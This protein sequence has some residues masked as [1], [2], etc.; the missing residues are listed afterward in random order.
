MR[1]LPLS[2]DDLQLLWDICDEAWESV[3]D[4]IDQNAHDEDL[5]EDVDERVKFKE[6]IEAMQERLSAEL[7]IERR[8]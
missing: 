4:W 2:K 1:I 7:L 6:Q 3:D 8:G 5:Q